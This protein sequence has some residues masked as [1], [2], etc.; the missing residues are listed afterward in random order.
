MTTAKI[1]KYEVRDI[2]RSRWILFYA[3]FFLLMTEALLRFGGNG[4]NALLSLVNVV[5]I[6]I[7]LVGIL[8]G[9]MYLYGAR[10][11]VVLLLTQPVNR[12]SLFAGLY[13][14]LAM[15]LAL[16]FAIGIAVPFLIHGH[17]DIPYRPLI[18]LLVAG[19]LLTCIFVA[20]AFVIAVRFED[21]VKGLGVAVLVWLLFTLLYDGGVLFLLHIFSDYPLET[22]V[23]GMMLLNP[24][25]L[26]RVALLMN[27][28]IAALMGYT[29]AAFEQFFGSQVGLLVASLSLTLWLVVPLLYGLRLFV[30]KDF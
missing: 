28:D 16:S 10:E 25:D 1:V 29:G 6:L 27:F 23:L 5:L 8:F 26:T 7:P 21:R 12:R 22:P 2:L 4:A 11:F 13:G 19:V 18:L 14:G 17:E 30:K 15:P 3:L 24:V 20:L 9:T